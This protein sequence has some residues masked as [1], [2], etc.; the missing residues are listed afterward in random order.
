MTRS[1]SVKRAKMQSA[2]RA[3]LRR[4]LEADWAESSYGTVNV[5]GPKVGE[6]R[7]MGGEGKGKGRGKRVRVEE[8]SG[9]D[10]EW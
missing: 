8:S 6:K 4:M 5:A 3:V 1:V 10:G 9:D 2:K 7:K